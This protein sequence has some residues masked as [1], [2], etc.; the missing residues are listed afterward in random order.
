LGVVR[1]IV[2]ALGDNFRL[3]LVASGVP[4]TQMAAPPG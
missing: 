1:M 2:I 4:L 3:L